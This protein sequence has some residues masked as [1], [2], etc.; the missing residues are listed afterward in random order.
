MRGGKKKKKKTK[1]QT[2]LDQ[3]KTEAVCSYPAPAD[4]ASSFSYCFTPQWDPTL[5]PVKT[6]GPISPA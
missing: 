5:L 6:R 1:P 2:N 3:T 4:G